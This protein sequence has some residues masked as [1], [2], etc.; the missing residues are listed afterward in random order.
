MRFINELVIHCAATRPD[1]WDGKSIEDQVREIDHWHRNRSD[2]FRKFGYH[3]FM[4]RDGEWMMHNGTSW[5]PRAFAEI[6]AHV[7]GHNARSIGICIA[8]GHGSAATDRFGANF[9]PAQDA[10]LRTKVVEILDTVQSITK[11]SGHNE[12]SS[13][14]CPGFDVMEW[15]AGWLPALRPDLWARVR[16][17]SPLAPRHARAPQTLRFGDRGPLVRRVQDVLGMI[18][19]GEF[20]QATRSSV[21]RFQQRRGLQPDGIVGPRTWAMLEQW[22]DE[23]REAA[24][25]VSRPVR[26]SWL[27]N[28]ITRIKGE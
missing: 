13:K 12:Y 8:G 10:A 1:F 24:P 20:D 19:T 3:G 22:G 27:Q 26:T 18:Q 28:L 2:P 6:G 16:R 11:V 9:T 5:G 14:S 15:L 25:R 23:E 17:D 21:I 7:E 4:T